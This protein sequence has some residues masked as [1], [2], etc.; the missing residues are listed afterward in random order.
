MPTRNKRSPRRESTPSE[1]ECFVLGLIWRHGP[2]SPYTIRRLLQDSPSTQWSGSAGSIYPLMRRLEHRGQLRSE[3]AA[4]GDRPAREYVI[5]EAGIEAMR[6]WIGPPLPDYAVTVAH[7]P[8]RSR[9]RFLDLLQPAEQRAWIA[10]AKAALEEVLARVQR[11]EELHAES[12][13]PLAAILTLSGETDVESR[14]RWLRE[15]EAMLSPQ[16]RRRKRY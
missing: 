16:R 1:L 7:D 2:S 3:P 12:D 11:W 14:T 15:A 13:E 8:L 10:A 6:A 4:T 5:T 9:I